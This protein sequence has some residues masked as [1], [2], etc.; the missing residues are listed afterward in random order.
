MDKIR[1]YCPQESLKGFRLVSETC[2][3]HI[4]RRGEMRIRED[5]V[6]AL[7]FLPESDE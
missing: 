4:S 7:I 6:L 5:R 2:F 1:S 3:A